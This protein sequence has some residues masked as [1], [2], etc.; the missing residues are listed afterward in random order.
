MK[1]KMILLIIMIGMII[2]PHEVKAFTGSVTISCN[3][4]SLS[5]AGTVKCT[6]KGTADANIT[7]VKG[8]VVLPTGASI[9]KFE[10]A[11]GWTQND[12]ADNKINPYRENEITGNF[13][14]GTL[15][16]SFSSSASEGNN[17]ISVKD[18]TYLNDSDINSAPDSN[19]ETIEIV[20]GIGL[21]NLEV[22]GGQLSPQFNTNKKAYILTLG[23]NATSFGL[24]ATPYKSGEAV[25]VTNNDTNNTISNLSSIAFA[26]QSGKESMSLTI[27]VGTG[28][29][30]VKYNILVQ[31]ELP[32]EIGTPTLASL[33][34][35]GSDILISSEDITVSVNNLN[36]YQLRAALS[37]KDNFHFVTSNLPSGCTASNGVL[38]CNLKGANSMPII[39]EANAGGAGGSKTYIVTIKSSSQGGSGTT[40]TSG[41]PQ[42]GNTAGAVM[43]LILIISFGASLFLYK[44]N[45]QNFNN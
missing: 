29:R 45:I 3:P 36:S 34:V 21:S 37:D 35:G 13:D 7:T 18:I 39:I 42:T 17:N 28:D 24:N 15:T 27:K 41:N 1:K 20:N 10:L 22:T 30:E 33:T 43:A 14:I 6:L 26:P 31:R 19:A 25:V 44:R 23:V 9:T 40:S 2:I 5:G 16:I 8:T 11:D 38:T 4:K 32:A 12:Y